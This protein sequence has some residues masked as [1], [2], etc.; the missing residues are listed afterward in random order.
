M[1]ARAR[2]II[3]KTEKR[4]LR[5]AAPSLRLNLPDAI[6][7][8][9]RVRKGTGPNDGLA[10]DR[11][12]ESPRYDSICGRALDIPEAHLVGQ[13]LV[14]HAK[15][16]TPFLYVSEPIG[17]SIWVQP[18][19]GRN[20]VDDDRGVPENA[21]EKIVVLGVEAVDVGVDQSLD[22]PVGCWSR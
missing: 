21:E 15:V 22:Y 19:I 20:A 18:A 14:G 5:R 6:A 7:V 17:R 11:D 1:K 16:L 8:R 13:V 12:S 9:E 2:A 3:K 4:R 10:L